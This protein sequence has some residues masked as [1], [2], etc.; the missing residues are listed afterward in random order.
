MRMRT[1]RTFLLSLT[2]ALMLFSFFR[3]AFDCT[4]VIKVK[5]NTIL[6][7]FN[8]DYSNTVP[9]MWI[10]PASEGRYGRFCFG[11]DENCKIAEGGLNE[12]GLFIAVNALNEDTD[13]KADSGLPDWEQWTGWFETGVPDGIL[14]KCANVDEAI[15]VFKN[16]NLFTLNKVKFLI[17]D[18]SR[19]SIVIEWSKNGLQFVERTK[20]YQISTNFVASNYQPGQYPCY[21]YRVAEQILSS[22]P[23]Q[24]SVDMMRSILSATHMEFQTPTV[25]SNIC[26]LSSGDIFIYYFHN[27]EDVVK[28]N[29]FKELKKGEAR[30]VVESL[31]KVKPYIADVY[32][33]FGKKRGS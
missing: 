27:Y 4:T 29:L 1:G 15:Q 16:Y 17:A 3:P 30:Y 28:I 19:D 5:G 9:R 26:N 12:K 11:F 2:T 31:F 18:K 8:L 14:A 7:G 22:G 20:D 10:I 25:Y 23:D 13:W 6:A 32:M 24:I 21:R 33:K